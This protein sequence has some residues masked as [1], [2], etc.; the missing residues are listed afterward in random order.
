M[1]TLVP[2]AALFA[3]ACQPLVCNGSAALCDRPL[4]EVAFPGT[5]NAMSNADDGWIAPNQQH[6]PR[7]QLAD[8][9]RAMLLDTYLDVDEPVLCHASCGLGRVPLADVL[10]DLRDFLDANPGEVVILVLQDALPIDA[11]LQAFAD[12]GLSERMIVAP[13]GADP[14]PTLGELVGSD[15]RLLV[16]R[17]SG[18]EGPSEYRPFYELGWDTPYDFDRVEAFT[19]DRLRGDV[20]SALFLINHWISDPLPRESNAVLANDGATLR[21]RVERC[22]QEAGRTPTILAVDFY[23]V[24]DLVEVV[25]GINGR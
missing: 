11:T 19:C 6:P 1:R 23:A 7:V 24:G 15:R 13:E 16:T 4:P 22:E 10:G 5:H 25:A 14:W 3:S 20:T 2:L 17:E 9:I 21:A 8:G 12:A 18:G